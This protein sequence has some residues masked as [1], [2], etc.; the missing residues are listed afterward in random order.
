MPRSE[1]MQFRVDSK[2]KERAQ[3]V[4]ERRGETASSVLRRL[5][6]WYVTEAEKDLGIEAE[7]EEE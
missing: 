2:I 7:E 5:L 1:Y 4:C 6:R 3:V